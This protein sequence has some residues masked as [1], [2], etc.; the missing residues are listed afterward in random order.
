MPA[1]NKGKVD[2]NTIPK[3]RRQSQVGRL[4]VEFDYVFIARLAKIEEPDAFIAI[5]WGIRRKLMRIDDDVSW[6]VYGFQPLADKQGRNSVGQ[7]DFQTHGWF[8][9]RDDAL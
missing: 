2:L 6:L 3:E 4:T 7:A 5:V 9:F 8:Y 1:V